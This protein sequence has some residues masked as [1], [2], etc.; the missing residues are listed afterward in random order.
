MTRFTRDRSSLQVLV[1]VT[2]GQSTNDPRN[3]ADLAKPLEKAGLK[4]V[5]VVTG[6][7][8]AVKNVHALAPQ[9]EFVVNVDS[10]DRLYSI[11]HLSVE[12]ILKGDSKTTVGRSVV[13][14][15]VGRSAVEHRAPLGGDYFER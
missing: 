9:D 1:V 7:Q 2:N 5:L 14:R 15:S 6:N 10:S 12:T 3:F 11:V 13:G 8:S 4:V